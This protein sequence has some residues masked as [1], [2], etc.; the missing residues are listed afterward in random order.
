MRWLDDITNLMYMN[1]SKLQVLVM[2][3]EFCLAAVNG[4]T[5]SWM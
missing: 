3:K 4:V 5:K 1:L 2:D